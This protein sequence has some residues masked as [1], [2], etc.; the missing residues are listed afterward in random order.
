M[1][2]L[3]LLKR[4]FKCQYRCMNTWKLAWR[5]LQF[6]GEKMSI[7]DLSEDDAVTHFGFRKV[8]LQEVANQI[9][10]RL[11]FYLSGHKGAVKVENDK[12]SLTY[13]TLLLLVLYRF[14][15]SRHL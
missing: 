4:S 10:P 5:T 13:E 3:L 14:S 7:A 2:L 9:W 12:Y 8:H 1:I 11:Q 6:N 15:R